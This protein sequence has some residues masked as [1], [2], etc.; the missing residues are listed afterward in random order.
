MPGG[1]LAPWLVTAGILAAFP[2]ALVAQPTEQLP[3]DKVATLCWPELAKLESFNRIDPIPVGCE[4][5]DCCPGCP[6]SELLD[7]RIRLRGGPIESAELE[8]D[9][10]TPDRA[11]SLVFE[12]AARKADGGKVRIE[13]GVS[14]IRRLPALPTTPGGLPAV[15]R[16]RLQYDAHW[17]AKGNAKAAKEE[18]PI[19]AGKA[20]AIQLI[21]E[22]L[23]GDVV[24]NEYLLRY[25]LRYCSSHE[26]DNIVLQNNAGSDRAVILIDGR[27]QTLLTFG[28]CKDD[29]EQG[30]T[31]IV[32][33]GQLLRRR[34]CRSEV[35]V[36]SDDDQMVLLSP[37]KPDW[38]NEDDTLSID[39]PEP[40]VAKVIVWLAAPNAQPIAE[41]HFT[42]ANELY[43]SGNAGIRFLPRFR[44]VSQRDRAI[45]GT[46]CIPD[47]NPGSTGA[48]GVLNT[49]TTRPEDPLFIKSTL[50]VYYVARASLTGENCPQDRNI[51]YV[52]SGANSETLA[53]EFGHSMGLWHTDDFDDDDDGVP[54]F[55]GDNLMWPATADRC[56][57]SEGQAFRLNVHCTSTLNL[58]RTRTGLTRHCIDTQ[59]STS[60]CPVGTDAH[61][62]RLDQGMDS[63]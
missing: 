35:A 44:S 28:A 24:V 31:T 15:G 19:A 48:Q 5:N 42:R 40:L 21:V 43:N 39:L 34:S 8:F 38:T 13:K 26:S 4:L 36:F 22:Q 14:L 54:E 9:N 25:N 18:M 51:Q 11:A 20:D 3:R 55:G 56:C 23:L 41:A 27:K 45:V 63:D 58:N 30:G 60:S 47:V 2:A 17:G 57:L 37:P 59:P 6:K 46:E 29:M 50:N 1:K 33:V 62:P 61:C 49:V 10:L 16:L 7:W 53:H 52:G 32:N 12:G